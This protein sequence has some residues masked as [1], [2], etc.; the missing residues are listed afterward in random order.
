M[1]QKSID[2]FYAGVTPGDPEPEVPVDEI[3]PGVD[4][5]I[6]KRFFGIAKG[7][8][9]LSYSYDPNGPVSKMWTERAK[10]TG[11]WPKLLNVWL[12]GAGA[13]LRKYFVF[14]GGYAILA[15][16]GSVKELEQP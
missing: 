12:Y 9:N 13:N 1:A 3:V 16:G 8:D 7:E 10:E 6:A 2:A 11:V 5:A 15:S 14:E 4:L